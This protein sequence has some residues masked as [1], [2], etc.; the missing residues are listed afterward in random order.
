MFAEHFKN[1]HSGTQMEEEY[2]MDINYTADPWGS[3]VEEGGH[4]I[5]FYTNKRPNKSPPCKTVSVRTL[6]LK[7]SFDLKDQSACDEA[8]KPH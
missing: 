3:A 4:K 5:I 6:M 2:I 7:L 8:T 1:N